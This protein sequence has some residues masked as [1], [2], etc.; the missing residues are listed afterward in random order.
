M[1]P[2][3]PYAPIPIPNPNLRIFELT[4]V[5]TDVPLPALRRYG[6]AALSLATAAWRAGTDVQT[7]LQ[8]AGYAYEV[9]VGLSEYFSSAA[10][11]ELEALSQSQDMS[12]AKRARTSSTSSAGAA[13]RRPYQVVAPSVKKYVK[14]CMNRLSELKIATAAPSGFIAAGTVG[15]VNPI[16]LPS[17]QEGTG[18][19]D[20]TGNIIHVKRLDWRYYVSDNA[21]G[22]FVRVIL[23]IDH[24]ANGLLAQVTDVLNSVSWLSC[25]NPKNVVGVGGSRF[26]ILDDTTHPLTM[27]IAATNTFSRFVEKRF[28]MNMPVQ[29]IANAG[30]SGDI[31]TNAIGVIYIASNA[32]AGIQYSAQLVFTDN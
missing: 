19:D 18:D 12:S 7:A 24:Q 8:Q 6:P 5:N 4:T 11:P 20:R 16:C 21:G 13:G 17:I 10:A 28:S 2:L 14:D 9:V 30:G 31:G 15:A 25:Y 3:L 27:Q 1:G 22:G 32:T 23:Y 29:Y 26:K